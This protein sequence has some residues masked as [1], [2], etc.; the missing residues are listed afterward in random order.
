LGETLKKVYLAAQTL[1]VGLEQVVL[2]R[3]IYG[4]GFLEQFATTENKLSMVS[5]NPQ[6]VETFDSLGIDASQSVKFPVELLIL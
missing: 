6:L 4:G 5:V 1:A 3:A 2:D